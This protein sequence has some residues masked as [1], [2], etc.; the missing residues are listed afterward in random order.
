VLRYLSQNTRKFSDFYLVDVD[1]SYFPFS[2]SYKV[3]HSGNSSLEIGK[4]DVNKLF[5]RIFLNFVDI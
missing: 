4:F 3:G 1:I 2:R 5:I